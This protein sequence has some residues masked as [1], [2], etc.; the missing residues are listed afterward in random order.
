MT[1]EH[2][3]FETDKALYQAK[4]EGRDHFVAAKPLLFNNC[5][6]K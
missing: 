5:G 1:I 6:R 3:L 2:L 4:K